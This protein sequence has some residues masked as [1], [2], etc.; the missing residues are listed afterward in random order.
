MPYF[1][2]GVYHPKK[3]VNIGTLWRTAYQLGASVIFTIG[4]KDCS[5]S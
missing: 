4:L 1:E 2:I 5:D 3:E